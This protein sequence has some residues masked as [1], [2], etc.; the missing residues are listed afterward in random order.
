MWRSAT[1]PGVWPDAPGTTLLAAHDVSYF[2]Q[3]DKLQVG[4]TVKFLTPCVTYLYRV[5]GHSIVVAGSPVYTSPSQ[6]LLVLETCYPLN[7]LFIMSQR[8]LVTASLERNESRGATVP[9]VLPA[10]L[11]SFIQSVSFLP[12]GLLDQL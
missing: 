6:S 12:P 5:T 10:G 4:Q 1:S 11:H 9:A 2:S 3:I 7:A 8:Y